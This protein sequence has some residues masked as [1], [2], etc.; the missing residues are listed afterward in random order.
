[1][2]TSNVMKLCPVRVE[3]N[4]EDRHTH[5]AVPT[6][7]LRPPEP[8]PG[9]GPR[10]RPHLFGVSVLPVDTAPAKTPTSPEVGCTSACLLQQREEVGG[11]G[12]GVQADDGLVPSP[13]VVL[14]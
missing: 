7:R 4:V 3:V 11:L 1:M 6:V 14:G 9:P 12:G 13:A 10:T 8:I 5:L 2:I